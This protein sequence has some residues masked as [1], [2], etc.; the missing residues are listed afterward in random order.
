MDAAL[1]PVAVAAHLSSVFGMCNS[2]RGLSCCG[3]KL[4]YY[5][6]PIAGDVI[7]SMT[8]AYFLIKTRKSVIS[9]QTAELI[10]SLIRLTFQTATPAAVV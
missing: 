9:T 7:L 5:C 3:F 10:R 4:S 1:I 2:W 8:T 6:Q